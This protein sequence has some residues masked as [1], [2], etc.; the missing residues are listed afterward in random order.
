MSST[1][2]GAAGCDV[3]NRAAYSKGPGLEQI[4][5]DPDQPVFLYLCKSCGTYWEFDIR[6]GHPIT[7]DEARN[8]FPHAFAICDR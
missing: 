2:T 6:E 1:I 8:H 3:C 4:A 7:E 5:A